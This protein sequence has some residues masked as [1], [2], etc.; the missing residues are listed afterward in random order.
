MKILLLQ[1]PLGPFFQTLSQALSDAGHQ[2]YKIHFNGGDECWPCVGH[3]ERFTGKPESW[4]TFF[5]RFIKRNGIDSLICYGDCRYYHRQAIR[6]CKL[7]KISIWALEEGYLRPDYVTLEQGGVNA[8]SPHYAKRAKLA[9]LTW[10]E[11]YQA[12][13]QVGK[14]FA[15]RAWYASRYHINK[16]LFRWRYPHFVNH[17]P[18][19]LY[20]EATGWIKSGIIKL[21]RRR[22]DQVL[23]KN[24]MGHKGHIFFIPLQV[25]EDFQL[26]EHS[27]LSNIE[28]F[29]AQVMNSFAEHAFSE[30]VL[31]FK[32]HPMDRGF[33]TYQP[34]IDRLGTLLGLKDRVFYGYELPLPALYPLLKGVI[35]I[36]STVGLSALLHD[37]PTF[38]MGRALYDMPGLT[39]RG[40]LERFWHKQNPVCRKTFE[41]MRQSLLHLTQINASFYR[42][43]EIGAMAV[44]QKIQQHDEQRIPNRQSK[45]AFNPAGLI[46]ALGMLSSFGLVADEVLAPLGML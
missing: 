1:G 35:T 18:W 25:T 2:V 19:S 14:T 27:D 12:Q 13:L 20:Q 7:K 15:R 26:R 44:V 37:V 39:T 21:C 36:N 43:L 30:D 42:H 9:E 40:T 32:H 29:I 31:L 45:R 28:D 23:L 3:N 17:R 22:G 33:V 34:Q 6:I 46:G 8:F 10:P 11:P 41:R 5:R 16:S 38:C 4:N 24:M